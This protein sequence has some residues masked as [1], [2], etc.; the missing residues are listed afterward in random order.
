[1]SNK[2]KLKFKFT[3]Y[4]NISYYPPV[5]DGLEELVIFPGAERKG[6]QLFGSSVWKFKREG[7]KYQQWILGDDVGCG[8][9]AFKIEKLNKKQIKEFADRIA[10]YLK[11]KKLLG[12]GNHFVDICSRIEAHDNDRT[13]YNML[14]IHSHGPRK[15]VGFPENIREAEERAVKASSDRQELGWNLLSLMGLRGAVAGD[16]NHNYV[17]VTD[18]SVIYRRGCIKVRE[19]KIH[20]LLAHVGYGL[21]VY[22]ITERLPNIKIK[23]YPLFIKKLRG[24]RKQIYTPEGWIY[25]LLDDNVK[26]MINKYHKADKYCAREIEWEVDDEIDRILDLGEFYMPTV[27]EDIKLKNDKLQ[28]KYKELDERDKERLNRLLFLEIFSDVAF[29]NH[30][31]DNLH[32]G[33]PPLQSIPHGT[34]RVIPSVKVS[35]GKAEEV[36]KY[37]Y[38]PDIV[39]S[40][41]LCSEHPE[42]YNNPTA[43]IKKFNNNIISLGDIKILAYIGHVG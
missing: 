12:G 36:R 13:K 14:L 8:L 17:E 16:W 25:S 33:M 29:D 37:V 38:V 21:L 6:Q 5:T 32:A 30:R 28:G 40:K 11:G 39:S 43:I 26:K 42:C 34:G 23:D 9:T 24:K 27:F 18:E 19:K 35:I 41:S 31:F 15:R 7:H 22:T 4:S 10:K 2:N 1:M 20:I 3:N